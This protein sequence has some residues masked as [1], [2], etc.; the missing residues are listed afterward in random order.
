MSEP[1]LEGNNGGGDLRSSKEKVLT[2]FTKQ[3]LLHSQK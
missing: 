2:R 3:A 1:V